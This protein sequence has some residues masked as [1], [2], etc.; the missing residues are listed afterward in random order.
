MKGTP[1]KKMR[2]KL[3]ITSGKHLTEPLCDNC[4]LMELVTS[5]SGTHRRC[6]FFGLYIPDW[7]MF[8]TCEFHTRNDSFTR[9]I[10]KKGGAKW[11]RD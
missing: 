11:E 5:G 4:G 8:P 3:N 9:Q 1:S 7:E 10:A 6:G 2:R